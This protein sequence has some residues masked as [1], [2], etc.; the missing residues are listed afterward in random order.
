[1]DASTSERDEAHGSEVVW[2]VA[3]RGWVSR[4]GLMFDVRVKKTKERKSA[5]RNGVATRS[6]GKIKKSTTKTT[7]AKKYTHSG[8]PTIWESRGRGAPVEDPLAVGVS[9]LRLE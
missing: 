8:K 5:E 2:W 4:G 1:M 7:G 3:R 6:R 9:L